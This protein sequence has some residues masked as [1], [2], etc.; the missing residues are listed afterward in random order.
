MSG[1]IEELSIFALPYGNDRGI[2]A[3]R[4][5]IFLMKIAFKGCWRC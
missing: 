3:E 5:L 4:V 1:N 2:R